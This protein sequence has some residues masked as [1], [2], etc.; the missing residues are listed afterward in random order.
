MNQNGEEVECRNVS[1]AEA[2]GTEKKYSVMVKQNWIPSDYS[3]YVDERILNID[4]ETDTFQKQAFY[5]LSRNSSVFV[6]AHTSSGKTLVAEYAISL[7]QKHGTRTIYTSPIKAL[8]NQK[9]HDFKQKYDDVGII[10]GDVQ[11][12]PTAKC[13]VMTTEILRNLV[14][15]NGDLLRDTE[16]V[17]FDEVHYI[18]DSE[19]GVVWEE[20]IIMIPRN[21]NFI[22][23]SATIPNGLEFSEWVGR[24]K[25]RTI[26]VISTGKRAV[27]LEHV[28]YCDWNVY[29][30][31]EGGKTENASNFK[32]DLVPF[33]KKNRPTGK[34][35][36]L[37]LANFVVKKK[38]TPAIFFCFSK[39]RCEDYAEILRTL[40][41]NDAKS[42]E[43]V[44]MFLNEAT[45]C[46][47]SEDK[48]LPQVL[49][50]SSMVLNGV[51][52]HHGSLLPFVK[53]CVE[54]LFSMNLVKLL[55]ATETF[56]MGV[57]MP[58]KCCVFLSLSKIDNG[59]FRYVSSGEYIQMSGRAG[60]RGMDA[61][62]TVMI[63]D[64]KMPPL[65]TIQG[66]I[67]GAPFSLSSQFKLSFGL[68]LISL[69]SNIRVEDLMRRSYGEHRSQRNYEKDMKKLSE[70]ERY[71][72]KEC[73]VCGDLAKY[74]NAVEEICAK[75]WK[76]I[77]KYNVLGEGRQI[78]LKN[79][80]VGTVEKVLG[81]SV[82][83]KQEGEFQ[84]SSPI[85]TRFLAHPLNIRKPLDRSKVDLADVFCVLEDGRAFWN[86]NTT[87]V[88]D[89]LEIRKLKSWY[90]YL[91]SEEKD[92]KEFDLHYL[93]ALDML[94]RRKEIEKI[95]TKYNACSLGMID[96]Y[97]N[98]M[99]FLRRK[100]FVDGTI[101]MKGRAGAEIHTVNE[102]LVVEMIFSNE[103]KEMCGRKIISL[104]SS[105]IHEEGGEEEP[106]ESLRSECEIM[107]EYFARL[108]KDLDELSIPPFPPLNFS[109]V[110]AVYDWC[111]GS[112]LVK[113]VSKYDVLEGTFVRLILRLEECC[114]ELISISAMIG[115]KD[116]EKKIEDASASMKR[117]IIFL[118]SLY[119]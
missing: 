8:S 44:K 1:G 17:V 78:L 56:A 74:I 61:V 42:R 41:L 43:E 11:V 86:Y 19:R 15:R 65:S 92:C 79:N 115:D 98:R 63:A 55:I 109:L 52:V 99:E 66:I 73:S 20:C 29:T 18:N 7:S 27:P 32:G 91:I 117:D 31:N 119:L 46:L 57:N 67:Q 116:L 62:G 75:N 28:I 49:N 84:S 80:S 72:G 77:G 26:Y 101:T 9:Y 113:I 114:R 106:G 94:H 6:S 12:N 4:F 71:Q 87:N 25:D 48:N 110:D 14:Y 102:V 70:L 24:T 30:I 88:M 82:L 90:D 40:N 2:K 23:L 89:V 81:T 111:N 39:R 58:A 50:M 13:L 68:I 16:F 22:M 112:S 3:Q 104:M 21:I 100:G 105:M 54:L 34:F 47:S 85:S 51:A 103:F 10:T 37:D 60:R 64:P 53:E 107:K 36:I 69:R 83:L 108:S 93:S 118:P 45:K 59:T 95:S 5:F 35:K 96:E 33:S 97:N 38:L 76:L